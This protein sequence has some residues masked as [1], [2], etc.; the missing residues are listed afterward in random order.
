M[1]EDLRLE[2]RRTARQLAA[3]I[4]QRDDLIRRGLTAGIRAVEL[5]A[6]AGLSR[7]RVYQIRD[8]R[9]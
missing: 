5:A 3:L 7:G 8:G 1:D 2:L 4:A 9:R 6:D